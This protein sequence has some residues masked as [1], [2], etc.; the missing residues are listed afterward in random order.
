MRKNGMSDERWRQ[1][2]KRK[3]KR[4][5]Q[6]GEDDDDDRDQERPCFWRAVVVVVVVCSDEN[7]SI[8]EEHT[9]IVRYGKVTQDFCS[10]RTYI[11]YSS[12]IDYAVM[13][14]FSVGVLSLVLSTFLR[15]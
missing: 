3:T 15:S 14:S 4:R 9:I 13:A 8:V 10:R 6:E 7:L 12:P 2:N 1:R 11:A 5:K